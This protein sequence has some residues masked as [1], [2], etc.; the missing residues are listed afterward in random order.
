MSDNTQVS[1][2]AGDTVRDIDRS[3]QVFPVAAKTQVVA[4]D[5]GG[6]NGPESIV[7]AANPLMVMEANSEGQQDV[8]SA[9]LIEL[10]VMNRVLAAGLNVGDEL[11]ALRRDED[12]DIGFGGAYT[13]TSN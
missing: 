3:A 5:Q 8:L 13:A 6:Q 10:R 7:S 12:A 4:L 9:I 11:N 1:S 2:G